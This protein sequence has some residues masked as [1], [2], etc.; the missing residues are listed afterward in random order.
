MDNQSFIQQHLTK[1]IPEIALLLSKHPELDKNYILSQ[2]NGLQKAQK[3]L[4]EFYKN[5][6][7]VYPVSLSIEQCSSEQT[8]IFKST[9]VSFFSF[10]M[11]KF[12][13]QKWLFF[14]HRD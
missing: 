11:S 4:P 3:K 14:Y 6:Q 2:I 8:A 12:T 10:P 5:K 13:P 9:V 7:I 1:P